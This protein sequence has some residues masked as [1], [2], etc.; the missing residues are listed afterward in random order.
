MCFVSAVFG[1]QNQTCIVCTC[2]VHVY[3]HISLPNDAQPG[4]D[5]QAFACKDGKIRLLNPELN[6]GRMQKGADAL[7]RLSTLGRFQGPP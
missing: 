7:L 4:A 2:F 3:V 1:P 5:I 6:A